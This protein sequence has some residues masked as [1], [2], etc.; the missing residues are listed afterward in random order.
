MSLFKS[1]KNQSA[2]AASTPAQTPRS[3]IDKHRPTQATKM[4][5]D[6]ALELALNKAV[7][8][9]PANFGLIKN[10]LAFSDSIPSEMNEREG[11]STLTWRFIQGA[12]LLYGIQNRC[13][14]VPIVGVDERKNKRVK[15]LT[16]RDSPRRSV[17]RW[18]GDSKRLV[19]SPRGGIG[20]Q[21]SPASQEKSGRVQA[22][23]GITGCLGVPNEGH[24]FFR[25]AIQRGLA[26]FDAS[27]FADE[28]KFLGLDFCGVFRMR[29]F[30]WM[31]IPMIK[32]DF[33]RKMQAALL[34][35]MQ[36]AASIDVMSNT[37][38]GMKS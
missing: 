16:C 12:L 26:N 20:S 24:Y 29:Q 11:F 9:M 5:R 31:T 1:N 19:D 8:T 18:S 36:L 17:C 4:T 34:A 33:G 35:C 37:T 27:S 22:L 10:Y 15:T 14:E 21:L 30:D 32:V 23:S 7:Q 2:S 38:D 13:L 25:N 6:Q 3:S 28:T